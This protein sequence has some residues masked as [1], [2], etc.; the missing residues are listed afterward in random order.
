MGQEFATKIAQGS[1]ERIAQGDMGLAQEN[2]YHYMV[3]TGRWN[4]YQKGVLDDI[5]VF[6]VGGTYFTAEGGDPELWPNDGIVTEFSAHGAGLPASVAPRHQH[7]SF[8]VTHSI[9]VSNLLGLPWE[10]G[11]TWNPEVLAS[12]DDH[13]RHVA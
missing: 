11:M 6:T 4:E 7:A 9:F 12:V 8:P 1:K 2:T 5:P 3:G 13:V 10:T